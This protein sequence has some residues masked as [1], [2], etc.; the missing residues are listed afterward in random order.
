M[1]F[2][3][4]VYS[5]SAGNQYAVAAPQGC[6]CHLAAIKQPYMFIFAIPNSRIPLLNEFL[7]IYQPPMDERLHWL[8]GTLLS[9][10]L[11]NFVDGRRERCPQDWTR[12]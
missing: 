3:N 1:S 11:C 6:M 7:P 8:A 12:G 4:I 10:S 5:A 9:F 2:N